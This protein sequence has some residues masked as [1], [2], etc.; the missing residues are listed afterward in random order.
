LSRPSFKWFRQKQPRQPIA[1]EASAPT[2]AQQLASRWLE[3]AHQRPEIAT[4]ILNVIG[5]NASLPD[6]YS[7]FVVAERLAALVYPKYKFSE[8]G[9]IFLDDHE[10]L[11][12]YKQFMDPDNWHSL[13][14]KYTLNQL[15]GLVANVPGDLAECG[16]Y[17]GASATLM[18]KLANRRKKQVHL[19]DSFLGLSQP[20]AIDGTYWQPGSLSSS[21]DKAQSNLK[22]FSNAHFYQG[23]I[24][25][26]FSEV[27][28]NRF[29]FVHIDVDLYQPTLD[30]ISFFYPRL[31]SRAI[32]LMDDY[33]FHSCPGAKA[34]ADEYF[35][36]QDIAIVKLPTGQA[37]VQK[38]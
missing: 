26:R 25:E 34:A 17:A 9:R 28:Q 24:P 27:A 2:Q 37:M 1:S 19:F 32:L 8:F 21:L 38:P 15:L 36:P 20:D 12:Y 10:F 30:S 11:E 5:A 31:E 18:C 6:E 29:C 33:G 3:F 22:D 16:V 13:D 4:E 35:L 14:R 23:W 7:R